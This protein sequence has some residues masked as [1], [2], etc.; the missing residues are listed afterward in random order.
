M[1]RGVGS[2]MRSVLLLLVHLVA[3][4]VIAVWRSVRPGLLFGT[5]Y[6]RSLGHVGAERSPRVS[7]ERV[8]ITRSAHPAKRGRWR[9]KP[10]AR[11]D[12]F[13][14]NGGVHFT[15]DA[16]SS[17]PLGAVRGHRCSRGR[18]ARILAESKLTLR[19]FLAV[20]LPRRSACRRSGQWFPRSRLGGRANSRLWT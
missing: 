10:E 18:S 5:S 16:I 15:Q 6:R 8:G 2:S 7:G 3:S 13:R 11:V 12:E 20:H 17:Q 9:H 1:V 19:S 4:W 14:V